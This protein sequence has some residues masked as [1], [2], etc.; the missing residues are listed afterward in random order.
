MNTKLYL[1]FV[2]FVACIGGF[3]FGFDTSVISGVIEFIQTPQ[4]FN[5]DDIQKGWAVSCIIIGCMIG[6]ILCGKPSY[7]FGRKKMLI[8]TALVFLLSTLGCALANNFTT[9]VIFR[10][11]AGG[12]CRF[13]IDVVSNVHFRDFASGMERKDG[14]F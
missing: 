11:F 5:L 6:A 3:L 10:I 8:F 13:G 4:V 14:I 2:C 9:F 12:F 7:V 1:I